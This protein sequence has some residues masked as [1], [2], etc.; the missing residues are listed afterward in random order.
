LAG[1]KPLDLKM[2]K[3]RIEQKFFKNSFYTQRFKL[4]IQK[5]NNIKRTTNF[6]K[7]KR[8]HADVKHT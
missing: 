1:G 4:N 8:V 2:K 3:I 7:P 6:S 5:D